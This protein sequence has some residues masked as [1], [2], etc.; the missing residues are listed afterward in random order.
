MGQG[1]RIQILNYSRYKL[2]T[3]VHDKDYV[4]EVSDSL[5]GAIYPFTEVLDGYIEY[6]WGHTGHFT[7]RVE[8]ETRV[9]TV[10]SLDVGYVSFEP[11]P[12][13]CRLNGKYV[14]LRMVPTTLEKVKVLTI[15]AINATG[16]NTIYNLPPFMESQSQTNW[17][18]A[19]CGASVGNY[20]HGPNTYKQCG[21][22]NQC[23][24]TTICCKKP[25]S[26]NHYGY[27][28]DALIAA[29]SF[30]YVTKNTVPFSTL[31][32][33]INLDQPVGTRVL[34]YGGGAHFMM[35]TGYNTNGQKITIQDP[36]Y[37]SST[38]LYSSYPSRYHGGGT[39]THTYYTKK[40]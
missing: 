34:W 2:R 38:I 33:K 32:S 17:C 31:Q 28:N 5:T 39:W 9:K 25:Q 11:Y 3:S 20:Y 15:T 36:W 24:K 37:G 35:I 18:W 21:I 10:E 16:S 29:K 13:R 6:S 23:Q 7:I 12:E 1:A 27:L 40:N 4:E 26:C 22:A 8:V 19:A 30:D 14:E